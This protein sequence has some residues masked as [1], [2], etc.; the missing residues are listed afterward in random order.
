MKILKILLLCLILSYFRPVLLG[1]DVI[2]LKNG[3]TMEGLIKKETP[4]YIELEL[5]F[6]ITKLKKSKIK[7][8]KRSQG[9]EIELM[10][11]TWEVEAKERQL[12]KAEYLEAEAKRNTEQAV[13][14]NAAK[15]IDT[16]VKKISKKSVVQYIEK[17]NSIGVNALINEE[18]RAKLIVDTGATSILL[19]LEFAEQ[20][21]IDL[22]NAKEI[23]IKLADGRISKAKAITLDSVK[24]QDME[25]KRVDAVILLE[26][27]TF[28]YWDGLLGM[29]FLN[30]FIFRIDAQNKQLILETEVDK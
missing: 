6:G 3:R 12:K 27:D 9:K 24:V 8:I 19:T 25:V 11:E 22:Y 28:S 17:R 21:N 29:S 26:E 10:Q 5:G 14:R 16:I 18:L 15:K 2:Y 13:K 30:N 7:K 23:K 20:L 1:A 4:E